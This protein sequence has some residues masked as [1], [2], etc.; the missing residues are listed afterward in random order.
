MDKFTVVVPTIWKS[1]CTLEL[2]KR[3]S[4]CEYVGEIILIDN[5]SHLNKIVNLPK[6]LHIKEPHNTFVN[7]AWNKGVLLSKYNNITI[8]NDD[9]LFDVNEYYHYINDI[10][11][12]HD[13]K[14]LGFI[15]MH[16]RNYTLDSSDDN[17]IIES[18]ENVTNISG[19]G[20]LITFHKD[21]WI[22][23]PE[24]IKIWFGDNWI[25]IKSKKPC[26]QLIGIKV[27]SKLGT[28]SNLNEFEDVKNNDKKLWI[29]I[30]KNII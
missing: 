1:E 8:S 25:H 13:L 11:A 3:Y 10:K 21:N 9:L 4:E 23:I 22:P 5:A 16:S 24:Q 19:W 20:C 7:P 26:L 28:T 6:V 18:Y 14:N 17:I 15:G 29:D 12:I 27:H 30:L 2:I